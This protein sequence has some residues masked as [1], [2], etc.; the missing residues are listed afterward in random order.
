MRITQSYI[1]KRIVGTIFAETGC[2]LLQIVKDELKKYGMDANLNHIDTSRVQSLLRM[3]YGLENFNGDVSLWDVSNVFCF[4]ECFYMCGKFN[5]DLSGWNVSKGDSFRR[6]FFG[7]GL[8]NRDLSGWNIKYNW[9]TNLWDMFKGCPAKKPHAAIDYEKKQ[10]VY[11]RI[12]SEHI[13]R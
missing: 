6:M 9:Y 7:C 2:D 1:P 11:N 3:F 4:D 10:L 12:V 13:K 8:F 5:C